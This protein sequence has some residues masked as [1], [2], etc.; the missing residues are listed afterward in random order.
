MDNSIDI[1]NQATIQDN[2]ILVQRIIA[3]I[4]QPS[5]HIKITAC[6]PQDNDFIIVDTINQIT[7]NSKINSKII[8]CLLN[9]KFINR[10]CY[11]FVFAKAIRTMQF[12]NPTTKKIFVPNLSEIDQQP[13]IEKADEMLA[14]NKQLQEKKDFTIRFL[15]SKFNIQKPTTKLSKFRELDFS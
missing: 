10:Y 13:F 6:I 4:T 2:S 9:S 14:V 1:Q 12:D 15:Q 7:V 5:D 8:R 11:R 3:H